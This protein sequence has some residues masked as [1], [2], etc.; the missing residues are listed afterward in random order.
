M[1]Y[2]TLSHTAHLLLAGAFQPGAVLV[3]PTGSDIKRVS[4]SRTPDS[5]FPVGSGSFFGPTPFDT[6]CVVTWPFCF[7]S[8]LDFLATSA[9]G[10]VGEG[11][12]RG[13][14]GGEGIGEC[15]EEGKG[16]KRRI[17]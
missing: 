1:A 10:S 12:G 5:P 14:E 9:C 3:A 7:T 8:V 4:F 6:V 2:T 13:G 17:E 11:E 16:D 15:R